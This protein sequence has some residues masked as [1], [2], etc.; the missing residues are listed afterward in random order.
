MATNKIIRKV[1]ANL[2]AWII[3]IISLVP[4]VLVLFNSFKD[5][6][7]ASDM[8]LMLPEFP[9][10]WTNFSN[11][12][13]KGKLAQSFF[14]SV[15]YS[16]A[17][18]AL[19]CILAAACAYVL[20]RNRSKVNN[21]VYLYLVLGIAMPINYVALMKV[22]AFFHFINSRPGLIL[23]YTAMQLPFAIFLLHGFISKV[24]VD[25]DEA[26]M[27]DG[28]SPLRLFFFIVLPLLKPALATVTVLTFLNTWNEFVSPLYFL[29]SSDK[30]PMTLSVYNFFGMFHTDWNL[31]CADIVLTILPVIIVYL[32][33]QKYIV[34][35][36]TSGAVKG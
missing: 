6:I 8:N 9:F 33:G 29:S 13:S 36:M 25:L 21:A 3:S 34:S 12:I 18:V 4:L 15:L 30:W 1:T 24:P 7:H 2:L 19:C 27:L 16:V 32:L 10:M 26:A 11:V 23:L 5:S 22:M 17:S 35:G 14:N 20:S 28:C 31:I